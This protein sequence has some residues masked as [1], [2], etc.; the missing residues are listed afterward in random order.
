MLPNGILTSFHQHSRQLTVLSMQLS[1]SKPFKKRIW[2]QIIQQKILN[3]ALCLQYL[4]KTGYEDLKFIAKAVESG[5][6]SNREAYAAKIYFQKWMDKNFTRRSD[7][8][9]NRLL[10]Y[11]YAILRGAMARAFTLYGFTPSLEVYHDNQLNSFNLADDF[12]EVFRP[13]VDYHVAQQNAEE[14]KPETRAALVNLLNM[15]IEIGGEKRSVTTAIEDM[16]KSYVTCC[17][18]QDPVYLKL[19]VLLPTRVHA[20]E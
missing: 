20:Y 12:M 13:L 18:Q 10:N 6:R 8:P 17:R 11:G 1:L 9:V 7:D 5:D 4:D 14:W 15:D 19:P 3:Q 2:Q 16:V